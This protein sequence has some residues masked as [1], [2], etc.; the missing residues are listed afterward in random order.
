MYL[1]RISLD[2]AMNHF[3]LRIFAVLYEPTVLYWSVYE[4]I[5]LA[6]D[7]NCASYWPTSMPVVRS[8]VFFQTRKFFHAGLEV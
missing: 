6:H 7:S 4:R 8:R 1:P 5:T 3:A 2:A